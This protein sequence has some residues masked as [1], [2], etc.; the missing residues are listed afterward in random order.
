[1]KIFSEKNIG[2]L[3]IL[4]SSLVALLMWLGIVAHTFWDSEINL[5]MELLQM[6]EEYI[7]NKKISVRESVL[8]FINSMDMR[9]KTTNAMLRRTLRDQVEQIHSIAM[10]LYRQNAATMNKDTL[11]ELIIEAIRPITFN[12]GRN[13]FF[14]R[15]MSGITK[16]WPPDPTQEGKSI[17]NNSNENRLQVF[18]SMFATVRHH[19]SGFNEYLW[20]KP[21]ED[22]DKLFQKIAYIKHFEPFD[23]YIGAGDYL[24]EVERDAQQHV[25]NII[26]QHANRTDN[27]YMFVLDLRSMKGGKK[28]AT[29]L[30]NPNQPDPINNLLSDEYQ[31]SE[32]EKFREKFL[33]GLKEHGEVFVKYRDKKPGSDEVRPKMSYFKLYPKWSWII[34]RG[35]YF[36][37]LIEQIDRIKEQHKKLFR[38]KI[39]ISLAIFCFILL[40]ALCISLLFSHK[41]RTLFL[42][43]RQRLE[44]SNRELTKAMDKAHA[45]TLAKSE[46]LANMSH[47][48][49]TPMN[50]IINLSELALET[51]LTDKQSDYM[52]K[53]LFS[54]KNLLEIINDILDFSKIE[55]GMLTLEK[56]YF[57]LSGLFDKLMLMFT[58][59]SQRKNLQLILDLS[60][61]LPEHVIGDPMRLYQVL[62]N[63][64][65]NAIKFTDEGE[66][67][68]Q[69][70]V[71][72]HRLDRAVIQFTVSDTGIGIA[73]EKIALLFESF[74]QADNSTARKYGGTGLGL[75]ICKRLVSLMGGKLSVESEVG[76][77]S[78]FSFSLSFALNGLEKENEGTSGTSETAAAMT[79]IR[80]A[81]ILLV[82]DNMINQQVAQE[83]LAKANL[84]VETV[85][86]GKEAVEA[87]AARDFDAV[88]MDIQMPVMD[89]YEATKAIRQDLGKTD[90]PILAMT[91]HAVSEE[92][93]K[94]FQIGMNDHI[95]KPINRN[96]LFLALSKWVGETAGRHNS[97]KQDAEAGQLSAPSLQERNIVDPL[98]QLL[99]EAERGEAPAGIDFAEGLQR[100]EG[101]EKLYLKL[102]RSFCR[103][104]QESLDKIPVFL[105]RDDRKEAL[106]FAHGLKGV[107]GN[108]GMSNL[109]KLSSQ[110][111]QKAS[112]GTAEDFQ[113]VFHAL[114][115]ELGRIIDY[116]VPRVEKE[117]KQN[118]QVARTE[119]LNDDDRRK[120][121]QILQR[122]AL[123]LEQSDF[124]SLQFLEGNQDVVRDLMDESSLVRMTGYIE[125]FHF[126]N[127]LNLIREIIQEYS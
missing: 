116:L 126:K 21:G 101:N 74:T 104:Q 60:S 6:E 87:V 27:E 16:L 1:M 45:A 85:C 41:V 2:K 65:G 47:E 67:I 120:A 38:E 7:K 113:D 12:N 23:W 15:S 51:E 96:N 24:V 46:F 125:G 81:R 49:R 94:C 122:L 117:E 35:F 92:R 79:A 19:G 10:H 82:E 42:S 115:L 8:D 99:A 93:D 48:I 69:A 3:I 90:L 36:D 18:N 43:Y 57:G 78:S 95:A 121:L 123:L 107:A 127:A 31:D 44:K 108:I 76:R 4:N 68:V 13:Y 88:L 119:P 109:Q 70:K 91:A 73:Q 114:T 37:D 59:Q 112:Y 75:T 39:R 86:N 52:K 64:I 22:P 62:S 29:M 63:L 30:V 14:I 97:G 25:T 54:S 103:E 80:Y 26:N 77:G 100:V 58:E 9:H 53:I 110:A 61:D 98:Q 106:L 118:K 50:G 34:A 32:G 111:E 28:F 11:E 83:I 105:K 124:S 33:N 17:Y 40:G 84:H 66:I 89:G 56:I 102:L 5:K 71:V 20:P 72:Q 55:A